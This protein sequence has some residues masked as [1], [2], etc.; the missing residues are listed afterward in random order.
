M[1]LDYDTFLREAEEATENERQ[2]ALK[3]EEAELMLRY[4]THGLER[5]RGQAR[6]TREYLE[7]AVNALD[8]N[9]VR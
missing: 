1:P 4:Y 5:A 8:K 6:V 3:A 7:A 2:W 9:G